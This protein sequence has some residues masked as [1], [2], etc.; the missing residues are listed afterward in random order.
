MQPNTTKR[1]GAPRGP[2]AVAR[3]PAPARR[4]AAPPPRPPPPPFF[5]VLGCIYSTIQPVGEEEQSDLQEE[6]QG[7]RKDLTA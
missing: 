5:V 4:A 1:G 7:R 3:P 2:R 6:S